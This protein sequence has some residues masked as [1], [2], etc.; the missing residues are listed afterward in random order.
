MGHRVATW[1]LSGVQNDVWRIHS[2]LVLPQIQEVRS[3]DSKSGIVGIVAQPRVRSDACLGLLA[4]GTSRGLSVYTLLLENDLPT[5]SPKWMVSYVQSRY[6][7]AQLMCV[8]G[9][10]TRPLCCDSRL[11]CRASQP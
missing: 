1:S 11:P 7:C 2:S 4:I 6:S 10:S 3:L 5:W 9:S 8:P